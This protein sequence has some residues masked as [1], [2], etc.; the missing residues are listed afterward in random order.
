M[1][2]F[3]ACS[4]RGALAAAVA[5]LLAGC[6]VEADGEATYPRFSL[7]GAPRREVIY[8]Y[9]ISASDIRPITGRVSS[10]DR[11]L[12]VE[13]PSGRGRRIEFKAIDDVYS[14]AA[15]VDLRPGAR[16]SVA[17]RLYPGPVFPDALA[18]RIVQFRDI[19]GAG[20]RTASAAI[21]EE[22][23][24]VDA[25]YDPA[26][27]LWVIS[28]VDG[29]GAEE[30]FLATDLA[31]RS[32]DLGAV[33][34]ETSL[35][36]SSIAVDPSTGRV[37]VASSADGAPIFE[38]VEVRGELTLSGESIV[39]GEVLGGD[40]QNPVVSGM[41][42]DGSG[43]LYVLFYENT[44][45]GRVAVTAVNPDRGTVLAGPADLPRASVPLYAANYHARPPVGDVLALDGELF[46]ITSAVAEGE[47]VAFRYD[48]GLSRRTSWGV[49]GD[50]ARSG[51]FLGPRRF[52]AARTHDRLL[53]ID[54]PDGDFGAS[55]PGRVV[56]FRFG[57]TNGWAVYEERG[58]LTLFDTAIDVGE[59]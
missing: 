51:S 29:E 24:P 43:R 39:L 37:F 56:A 12:I 54:Q 28:S 13:V 52:V 5:L 17:I 41:S 40:Y 3:R 58:G 35:A 57:T 45:G 44:D 1:K 22:F 4:P 50:S 55:E 47:P 6:A 2:Q 11:S 8:E 38:I 30:I 18:N 19:G 10:N 15:S 25:A 26:G 34:G 48:A 59:R 49:L 31:P 36:P 14:G 16:T 9:S 20:L 23:V 53:V 7:V 33:V 27:R 21:A 46:V 42:V 32:V